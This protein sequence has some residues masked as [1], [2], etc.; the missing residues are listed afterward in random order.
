M[1][2]TITE[3]E[4]AGLT[5]ALSVWRRP[6]PPWCAT[7]G[8]HVWQVLP[9]GK[10]NRF[11]SNEVVVAPSNHEDVGVILVRSHT[12]ETETDLQLERSVQ[13]GTA[14]DQMAEL[15]SADEVDTLVR[16]LLKARADVFPES[17]TTE[18]QIEAIKPYV[19]AE[20]EVEAAAAEVAERAEDRGDLNR[21][22]AAA[23]RLRDAR[24][25]LAD[26]TSC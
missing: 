15:C 25:A 17:V 3:A 4:L 16:T 12:W 19:V 22:V 9:N 10:A 24:R 6:C 21:L 1:T 20:R 8:Q 2:T 5:A 14:E 11:H 7:A 13:I 23:I 26:L 18:G